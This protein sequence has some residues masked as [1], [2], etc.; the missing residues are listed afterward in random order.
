MKYS[1][2]VSF[3][4]ILKEL[5][6]DAQQQFKQEFIKRTEIIADEIMSKIATDLADSFKAVVQKVSGKDCIEIQ[7]T[8]NS[9]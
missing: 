3:E 9:K 1:N 6:Y 8:L 5:S 2:L 4:A 7:F